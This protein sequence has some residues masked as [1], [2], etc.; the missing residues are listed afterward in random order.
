MGTADRISDLA[1]TLGQ[2]PTDVTITGNSIA[3]RTSSQLATL[4]QTI[5]SLEN[6]AAEGDAA[7]AAGYCATAPTLSGRLTSAAGQTTGLLTAFAAQDAER[8]KSLSIMSKQKFDAAASARLEAEKRF[9]SEAQTA[10]QAEAA[11]V[12]NLPISAP[13]PDP[14]PKPDQKPDPIPVPPPPTPQSVIPGL[15]GYLRTT[16]PA[17]VARYDED[18]LAA[19]A[20]QAGKDAITLGAKTGDAVI[21]YATVRFMCGPDV[22]GS[23]PAFKWASDILGNT[24]A[25]S[26]DDRLAILRNAAT[27]RQT[28]DALMTETAPQT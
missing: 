11:Q 7:L 12:G 1:R 9:A 26:I 28:W 27:A 18:Q 2:F 25:G 4:N 6:V 23:N 14:V 16:I 24:A 5:S 13:K 3:I 17:D 10:L 20:T 19:L 21:N 8:L 22:F 15:P